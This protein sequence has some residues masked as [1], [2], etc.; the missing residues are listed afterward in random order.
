MAADEARD[1]TPGSKR[2]RRNEWVEVGRCDTRARKKRR[3]CLAKKCQKIAKLGHDKPVSLA[4]IRTGNTS[5]L[6]HQNNYHWGYT[7]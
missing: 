2:I 1:H 4:T 5:F 7:E 6:G 3:V